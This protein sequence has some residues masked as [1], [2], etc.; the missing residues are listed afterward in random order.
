MKF[1]V[2]TQNDIIQIKSPVIWMLNGRELTKGEIDNLKSEADL[3]RKT[4]LWQLM[5]NEGRYHAQKKGM[6]DAK[7]YNDLLEARSLLN[8]TIFFEKFISIIK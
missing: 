5:L 1:T 6:V 3:I 2:I 4:K 7:S 8:A